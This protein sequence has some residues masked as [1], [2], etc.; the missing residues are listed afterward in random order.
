MP[1]LRPPTA[2]TP[3]G[4]R[5]DAAFSVV[6]ATAAAPP[7][8]RWLVVVLAVLTVAVVKPWSGSANGEQRVGRPAADTN[9]AAAGTTKTRPPAPT[10]PSLTAG[11]IASVCLDPPSWRL[12]TVERWHDQTIR[13]WRAIEP[14]DTAGGPDDARVPVT[15]LVSE[16]VIEL[17]WCAPVVAPV[18]T[19]GEAAIDVWRRTLDGAAAVRVTS[20]RPSSEASPYGDLY[21]PPAARRT[22]LWNDGTYVFRHRAPGGQESWF[23]VAVALRPATGDPT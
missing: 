3:N 14:V 5:A 11:A 15:S 21:G 9:S 23:A 8:G 4:Q 18:R 16:G 7:L 10:P 12:A 22:A 13:V 1:R 6:V 17:G 20:L 19:S 2:A